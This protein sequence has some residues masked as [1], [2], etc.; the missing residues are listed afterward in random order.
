MKLCEQILTLSCRILKQLKLYPRY[1]FNFN[2]KEEITLIELNSVLEFCYY[3]ISCVGKLR[4][5]AWQDCI[6]V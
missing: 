2:C 5:E 1:K 4:F 3:F 6:I